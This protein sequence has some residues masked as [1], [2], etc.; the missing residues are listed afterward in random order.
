MKSRG[1]KLLRGLSIS[2]GRL[3]IFLTAM[4][5]GEPA[6]TATALDFSADRILAKEKS[7][8]T[9]HANAKDDRGSNT[10]NRNGAR[11]R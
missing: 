10:R 5:V 1:R 2:A 7:V 6:Q 11:V 4:L 9:A 8:V 3:S